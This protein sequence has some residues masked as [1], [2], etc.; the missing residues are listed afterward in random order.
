MQ[1]NS[2]NK[3]LSAIF[4]LFLLM[5]FT[6]MAY[7]Q[8]A[9]PA[10]AP[11]ALDLTV[12][13]DDQSFKI[14]QYVFGITDGS[15][16]MGETSPVGKV[17]GVFN[18]IILMVGGVFLAYTLI[19]G[20]MQTAHDG[21]MMGKKW[22]SVW[23]PIR[24]ALGVAAVFPMS[25]GFSMIQGLVI[26]FVMQGVGAANLLWTSFGNDAMGTTAYFQK[27]MP[28]T[29][30]IASQMFINSVCQKSL[31]YENDEFATA[32]GLAL[33]QYTVDKKASAPTANSKGSLVY[34]YEEAGV[35]KVFRNACGK[36]EITFPQLPKSESSFL[37]FATTDGI[38]KQ[39]AESNAFYT[40]IFQ[41]S[42]AKM[43]A[44]QIKMDAEATTFV[45][46]IIAEDGTQ[47]NIPGTPQNIAGTTTVN[48]ANVKFIKDYEAELQAKAKE[49]FDSHIAESNIK[50]EIGKDGWLFAGA[51]FMK[52]IHLQQSAQ[53]AL[54]INFSATSGSESAS[55]SPYMKTNKE[56]AL[57]YIA[58]TLGAK[59]GVTT[60]SQMDVAQTSAAGLGAE[61]NDFGGGAWLS[62]KLVG[63]VAF[64]GIF[65]APQTLDENA[66]LATS[67]QG[68]KMI[69]TGTSL[70]FGF[71]GLNGVLNSVDV[72]LNIPGKIAYGA[73]QTLISAVT[74]ASVAIV[75][76]GLMLA[77]YL[78]F[79]PYILWMGAIFG[80]LV[81]VVEA[82]IAAPL[83]AI[84]HIH[85]HGDDFAGKGAPGYNLLLSLVLRPSL[86]VLGLIFAMVL[87][88]P[89]VNIL[90]QTFY[91]VFNNVAQGHMAG[92]IITIGATAIYISLL[93]S[94][95]GKIFGLI[96]VVPDQILRWV[97]VGGGG[98]I[99]GYAK[100]AEGKAS[101]AFYT[102]RTS[103]NQ[104]MSNSDQKA[105][106]VGQRSLSQKREAANE[107]K[108]ALSERSGFINSTAKDLNSG[109]PEVKG[110]AQLALNERMK[111]D[112][113]IGGE[114]EARASQI[115]MAGL[116]DKNKDVNE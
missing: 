84:M 32:A 18:G 67:S 45:N 25:N 56:T 43:D 83:W 28:S 31:A 80:W 29:N 16:A 115:K 14:M 66:I 60:E 116:G 17:F 68:H 61:N 13:N 79:L 33:N 100:E 38:T 55:E 72:P 77:L 105:A 34:K 4:L 54:D 75:G 73:S 8:I 2:K 70:I 86:M 20:T 74:M 44:L 19:I 93:V 7:A 89:V 42:K 76:C 1:K 23:V 102:A 21:E 94:L 37:L 69:V 6:G 88:N 65:E 3:L 110:A 85:P 10:A 26:W 24:T 78:P 114:V 51:Y 5:I 113:G 92:I 59:D 62:Q 9:T 91:F 99:G 30:G 108:S 58:G 46:K 87:V 35:L 107:Q 11:S 109:K 96:H 97:G 71:A 36:V 63:L 101:Q 50:E 53:S 47:N 57:K 27:A 39:Q 111:S 22:S 64:N 81:L 49:F 104:A 40:Q 52:M 112:P 98:D 12:S 48:T 106:G 103:S 41:I 15:G 82:V 95:F 90:R